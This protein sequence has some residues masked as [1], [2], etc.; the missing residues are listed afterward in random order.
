MRPKTSHAPL[1]MLAIAFAF[2]GAKS[3]RAE[4]EETTEPVIELSAGAPSPAD[5]EPRWYGWKIAL[6][7]AANTYALIARRGELEAIHLLGYSS[8]GPLIHAA[9]QN[10]SGVGRSLALRIGAPFVLAHTHGVEGAA[11]G[12]IVAMVVDAVSLGW[13]DG[14]RPLRSSGSTIAP[15]AEVTGGG[16]YVG[17][18][19]RF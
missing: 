3:D 2:A 16:V 7:D 9:R 12:A 19:G 6:L 17:V 1:A 15:T 8:G 18:G 14:D 11:S 4:A 5:S 13:E 10:V